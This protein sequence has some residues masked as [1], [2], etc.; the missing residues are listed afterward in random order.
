MVK[1][2][3]GCIHDRN[4]VGKGKSTKME[5]FTWINTILGN[6]KTA[7]SG[8]YHA[9]DFEKYPH[10]VSRGVSISFQ[11]QLRSGCHAC[12]THQTDART[13]RRPEGWLRLSLIRY[14]NITRQSAMSKREWQYAG[15]HT[16]PPFKS[17]HDKEKLFSDGPVAVDVTI[18]DRREIKKSE[19]VQSP[20]PPRPLPGLNSAF[21]IFNSSW[22]TCSS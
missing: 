4:I 12:R 6:L 5:C 10:R 2:Q 19:Y 17:C 8:T 15:V 22:W 14:T 16:W 13:G 11:S 7:I 1:E 9:F 18:A 21:R 3:A 20:L